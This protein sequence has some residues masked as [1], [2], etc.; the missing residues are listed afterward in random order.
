MDDMNDYGSCAQ[1]KVV[2][3]M[4]ALRSWAQASRFYEQLRVVVDMNDS[5]S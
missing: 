4:N 2:D 5:E 3:N 1:G